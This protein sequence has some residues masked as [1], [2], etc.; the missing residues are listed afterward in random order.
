MTTDPDPKSLA[1]PFEEWAAHSGDLGTAYELL[2]RISELT[3]WDR[4]TVFRNIGCSPMRLH[5][6]RSEQEGEDATSHSIAYLRWVLELVRRLQTVSD[7]R[8]IVRQCYELSTGA[9]GAIVGR[10][11]RCR[12]AFAAS[13]ADLYP[14]DEFLNLGEVHKAFAAAARHLPPDAP[15]RRDAEDLGTV[16]DSLGPH[17]PHISGLRRDLL[18]QAD[19]DERLGRDVAR[20]MRAHINGCSLCSH[21][22]RPATRVASAA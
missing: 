13:D 17:R 6:P 21:A 18:N 8:E 15:A 10:V 22:A 14:A 4:D 20:A 1:F 16:G 12:A 11:E 9:G 7:R 5:A 19:A 3:E 2:G